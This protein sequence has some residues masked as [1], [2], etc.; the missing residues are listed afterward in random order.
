MAGTESNASAFRNL[1][2]GITNES[3]NANF[4]IPNALITWRCNRLVCRYSWHAVSECRAS[5]LN[6][7]EER[8]ALEKRSYLEGHLHY[9]TRG[10][11]IGKLEEGRQITGVTR[12]FNIDRGVVSTLWVEFQT[13]GQFNRRKLGG[14]PR[15]TTAEDDQ[16]I[17]LAAK[18][19][20]EL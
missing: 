2:K 16:Y 4:W 19:E 17:V 11:L 14:R 7:F 12:L 20:P 18:R 15:S 10:R 1:H 5:H 3:S 13:S 6:R 9:F 8:C